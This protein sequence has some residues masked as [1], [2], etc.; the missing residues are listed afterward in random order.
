M[1][2]HFNPVREDQREGLLRGQDRLTLWDGCDK[3]FM[4]S[5]IQ[6]GGKW[7]LF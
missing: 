3:V 5:T 7:L 1:I 2:S 6:S 4:F